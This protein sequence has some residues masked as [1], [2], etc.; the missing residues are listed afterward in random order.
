MKK[1]LLKLNRSIPDNVLRL[2]AVGDLKRDILFKQQNE[3]GK[4]NYNFRRNRQ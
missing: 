4:Q 3:Y 1:A 2:G